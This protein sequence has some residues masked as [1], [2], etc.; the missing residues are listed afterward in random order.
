MLTPEEKRTLY[1][2]AHSTDSPIGDQAA[3]DSFT[4]K[5][6]AYERL[7]QV[8]TYDIPWQIA[9]GEYMKQARDQEQP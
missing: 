2:Y 7:M 3:L 1:D 6:E 8:H 4:E 5:L 9:A